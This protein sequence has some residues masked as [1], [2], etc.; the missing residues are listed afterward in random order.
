MY[1]K[2]IIVIKDP[3][4]IFLI[5]KCITMITIKSLRKKYVI[6]LVFVNSWDLIVTKHV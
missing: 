5:K 2:K 3:P 4:L 6:V 1:K